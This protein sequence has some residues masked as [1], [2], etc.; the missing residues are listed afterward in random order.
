MDP[1]PGTT[2][3]G[4]RYAV[5]IRG[6]PDHGDGFYSRNF[7]LSRRALRRAP[8]SQH[9]LLEVAAGFRSHRCA[10]EGEHS[11]RRSAAAL[12]RHHRCRAVRHAAAEQHSTAGQRAECCHAMD[13]LFVPPPVTDAALPYCY[14]SWPL[15]CALLRLVSAGFRLGPARAIYLGLLAAVRDLRSRED[16]L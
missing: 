14:R 8:R 5:R 6:G 9:P 3:R 16:C 7:L 12:L 11:A 1:Y 2:A 13:T 10:F 15:V 4:A